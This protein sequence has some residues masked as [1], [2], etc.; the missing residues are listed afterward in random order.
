MIAV[1]MGGFKF[2]RE[3]DKGD[4]QD[5][6]SEIEEEIE[7]TEEERVVELARIRKGKE[8]QKVGSS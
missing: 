5:W 3:L 8:K 6:V 2:A 1:Q 7:D 4:E